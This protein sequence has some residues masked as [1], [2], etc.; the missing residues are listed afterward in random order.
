M[1]TLTE[2]GAVVLAGARQSTNLLGARQSTKLLLFQTSRFR[3]GAHFFRRRGLAAHIAQRDRALGCSLFR[4][5]GFA[6]AFNFSG[7]AV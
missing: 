7:V 2:H 6:E 5:H 1:G 4:R 3:R